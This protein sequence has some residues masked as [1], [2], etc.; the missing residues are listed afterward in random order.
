MGPV[1]GSGG[2]AAAG[3]AG[4]IRPNECVRDRALHGGKVT[5]PT[6]IRRARRRTCPVAD[7]VSQPQGFWA[8]GLFGLSK[9]G[10]RVAAAKPLA[11]PASFVP[12]HVS[13]VLDERRHDSA[14][15]LQPRCPFR[16]QI[17]VSGLRFRMILRVFGPTLRVVPGLP[18]RRITQRFPP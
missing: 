2:G 11:S 5:Q 15:P 10:H 8:I 3:L 7:K 14:A 18:G 6:D 16:A 9:L 13:G 4:I 12:M 1:P 17:A